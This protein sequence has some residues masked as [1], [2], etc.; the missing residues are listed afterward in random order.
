MSNGA[1]E[2]QAGAP[3]GGR[4]VRLSAGTSS[5]IAEIGNDSARLPVTS[6]P[7]GRRLRL[8]RATVAG[9]RFR[10]AIRFW[11]SSNALVKS[12][13]TAT[14]TSTTAWRRS[15][16]TAV[17]PAT[18][19]SASWE[20]RF[21]NLAQGETVYVDAVQLERGGFVTPFGLRPSETL[22]RQRSGVDKVELLIDGAVR[23][24]ET[25]TCPEPGCSLRSSDISY[26]MSDATIPEGLHTAR[27]R[28]TDKAG[29]PPTLGR[30]WDLVVDRSNPQVLSTTGPLKQG[31]FFGAGKHKV[32]IEA[33]D[34][35]QPGT[36]RN[37]VARLL[38]RARHGRTASGRGRATAPSSTAPS[39][40]RTGA[41]TS[42]SPRTAPARS[43]TTTSTS[44]GSNP[45]TRSRSRRTCDRRR[46]RAARRP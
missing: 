12:I 42:R 45:A 38:V 15:A 11:D 36:P 24:T 4:V 39:R 31:A 22:A 5:T 28:A 10:A 14:Q 44:S 27:V 8:R 43:S 26:T 46:R 1:V 6:G 2:T 37:L 18:A 25:G 3:H 7:E 21:E 16:G 23:G 29:N 35:G 34:F 33:T 17:V 13:P 19:V 9:R 20:V 32:L 40:P 30:P 41:A